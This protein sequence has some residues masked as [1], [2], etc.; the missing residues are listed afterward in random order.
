MSLGTRCPMFM[1]EQFKDGITNGAAWY[2]VTGGMQ[3]WNY[4]AA[5][6]F[7]LTIEVGCSKFPKESELP[8]FWSANREPLVKYIEQ[9]HRGIHGFVKS[10]I[11]TPIAHAAITLNDIKHATYSSAYGDYWKL[12]L[13]GKYNITVDAPGFDLYF[14]EVEVLEGGDGSTLHD[15]TLMRDDVQHWSSA[16]DYR[17]LDNVIH[18]RLALN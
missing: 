4:L 3:D 2:S 15:I 6:C 9:V 8:A 13:P 11:G 7:E 18:T 5:G 12:A 17:V 14:A 10:S 16:Y 1:K